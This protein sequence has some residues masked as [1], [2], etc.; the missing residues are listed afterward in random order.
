MKKKKK[1]KKKIHNQ[2]FI[3]NMKFN[4]KLIFIFYIQSKNRQNRSA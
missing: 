1:K 4:V 3:W 2:N